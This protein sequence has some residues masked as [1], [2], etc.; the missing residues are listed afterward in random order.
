[1]KSQRE[2][3]VPL[4]DAGLAILDSMKG[5]SDR[6]VFPRPRTGRP[7]TDVGLTGAS[8]Y[9]DATIHG[10]RAAFSAWANASEAHYGHE[11]I[12]AALAHVT[13]SAVSRRYNR[14]DRFRKRA[15]LMRDWADYLVA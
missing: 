2:H 14:S 12:G 4:S 13:G 11:T 3:V 9:M 6:F 5:R 8:R 15:K 1:M 10:C 7:L